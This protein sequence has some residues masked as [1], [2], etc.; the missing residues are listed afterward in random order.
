MKI[1]LDWLKEWV[2]VSLDAH[3]L[4]DRLTHAGLE[5][6]SVE[7]LGAGLSGIVVGEILEANPHPDADRLRVCRV[8]GDDEERMIVCGAPN[9]RQGLKAPLAT[10]GTVMPNGMKIKPAKLRGVASQGM[11]CSAAELGLADDAEAAAGLMALPDDAPV[12]EALTTYLGL[13]DAV[14]DIDLTPNRADCLSIRGVARE[15]AALTGEG[16]HPLIITPVEPTIEDRVAIEVSATADCPSYCARVITGVNT[17]AQTPLWMAERLRRAGIRSLSPVV[18]ITNYVLL[19]LGQPMHAFDHAK[20]RGGIQVRRAKQNETITLLDQQQIEL[21]EGCLVIAD[22][23]EPIALAGIMGGLDSAV[24]DHTETIVLESAWFNPATIAGRGRRFGLHTES[25]HRFERGVDPKLQVEAIERAT[26]LVLEIA[27][28]HAGPVCQSIDEACLPQSPVVSLSLSRANALLGTDFNAEHVVGILEALGMSVERSD[29]DQLRVTPPSARQDIIQE[30][31]LIEEVARVT[32]YDQLP[33]KPPSGLIDLKVPL[34]YRLP[35]IRLRGYLAARGFQEVMT[36][37]FIPADTKGPDGTPTEG[38]TLANPLSQDQSLM[39]PHLLPGLLEVGRRNLRQGRHDFRLFEL[40]QCFSADG[41]AQHLGLLMTGRSTPEHFRAHS[42]DVDF[43]DLKG[44]LEH[45]F[46]GLQLPPATFSSQNPHPWLHPAKSAA[47]E[48]EGQTVGY[49][50]QLHPILAERFDLKKNTLVAELV[51]ENISRLTPPQHSGV[52]KFPS[53]R[54]DLAVVLAEE[55][56]ASAVLEV[57]KAAG[58][59]LLERVV[60]FDV[61]QGTGIEKGLKSL[62]IGLIIRDNSRTLTDQDV[63][64]VSTAVMSALAKSFDARLRG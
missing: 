64:A 42:D 16:H 37:S 36:W 61:Y 60:I 26:A 14:I 55:I 9:A 22:V 28:G 17:S 23:H 50:G 48:V 5:V 63:D 62:G 24:S 1:S 38:L 56:E 53:S 20:I 3:A 18:D 58:D 35:G 7:T 54:R 2:D 33:S 27:G 15:V 49:L 57:V 8:I 19:E 39:R 34:E 25:S 46:N 44:E 32:G 59:A 31:D 45:L 47:I 6:D 10:M 21:D 43:Y 52:S 11:L 40:G 29:S 13:D 12:G 4:A 30:V 41:E 51:V